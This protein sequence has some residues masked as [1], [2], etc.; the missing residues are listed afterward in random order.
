MVVSLGGGVLENDRCFELIRSHGTLIYLKSSPEILTLRL[1]HKTDRPC[2][3]A[4]TGG[5]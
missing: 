3:K 1:Q 5:S 2:S 4:R